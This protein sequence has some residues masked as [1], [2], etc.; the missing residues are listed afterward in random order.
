MILY[1]L[2][3]F[4]L[5]YIYIYTYDIQLYPI[6]R[7]QTQFCVQNHSWL[8][9]RRIHLI[10]GIKLWQ[11]YARCVPYPLYYY[12]GPIFSVLQLKKV[13]L[14]VKNFTSCHIFGWRQ[15]RVK[16]KVFYHCSDVISES[17][18]ILRHSPLFKIYYPLFK[19]QRNY[20]KVIEKIKYFTLGS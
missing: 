9:W 12:S 7:I 10:L 20:F 11:Q 1:I 8:T 15:T 14:K 17:I 4:D 5:G 2:F 6:V 18:M 13:Q 16:C 3:C 19:I